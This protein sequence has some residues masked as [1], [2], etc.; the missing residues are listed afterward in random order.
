M[1]VPMRH[2][3][4]TGCASTTVLVVPVPRT[5]APVLQTQ[6]LRRH[7]RSCQA[8]HAAAARIRSFILADVAPLSVLVE[9]SMPSSFGPSTPS[10]PAD[11]A[12]IADLVE[13][14]HSDLQ[15][16][17]IACDFVSCLLRQFRI[18]LV[19]ALQPRRRKSAGSM[20]N[21]MLSLRLDPASV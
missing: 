21:T 15:Q 16:R 4:S 5:V 11:S 20:P 17:T 14:L 13:L 8:K 18:Q 1:I 2:Q 10:E 7:S 9:Q 6:A 3:S 12:L 19:V